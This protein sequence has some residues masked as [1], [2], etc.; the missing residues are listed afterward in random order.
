[1]NQGKAKLR[2][3]EGGLPVP[4]HR[5]LLALKVWIT[6]HPIFAAQV[7]DDLPELAFSIG[8]LVKMIHDPYPRGAV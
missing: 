6:S 1:M 3:I 8:H 2:V 5:P 7:R 4:H